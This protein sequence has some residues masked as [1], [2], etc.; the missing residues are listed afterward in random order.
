M[1]GRTEL[2]KNHFYTSQQNLLTSLTNPAKNTNVNS[3]IKNHQS[4]LHLHNIL[5]VKDTTSFGLLMSH[6]QVPATNVYVKKHIYTTQLSIKMTEISTLNCL[7]KLSL[8]FTAKL[9]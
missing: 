3:W 9:C 1:D 5:A 2:Y 6:Q 8:L 7:N 4:H